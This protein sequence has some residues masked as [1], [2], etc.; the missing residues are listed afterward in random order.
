MIAI[1]SSLD[2]WILYS[3]PSQHRVSTQDVFT[4]LNPYMGP[5]ILRGYDTTIK[6]CGQGRLDIQ[7]RFFKNVLHVP[8]LSINMISICQITHSDPRKRVEFT[9]NSM[10]ISEMKDNSQIVV[11]EVNYQSRLYTFSKFVAKSDYTFLL[12]HANDDIII[13]H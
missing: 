4:S 9:P 2:A 6:F 1:F 10:L 8:K 11:G 7:N 12:A 5:P 13:W 3:S